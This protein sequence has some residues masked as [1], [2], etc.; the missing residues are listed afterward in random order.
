MQAEGVIA[1]SNPPCQQAA[2]AP[3]S[4]GASS[5]GHKLVPS[6]GSRDENNNFKATNVATGSG[7]V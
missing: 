4:E 1:E 5:S 3:D 7:R 6:D 2:E